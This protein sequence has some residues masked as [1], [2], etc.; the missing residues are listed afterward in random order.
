MRKMIAGLA[1]GILLAL[2]GVA[3]ADGT[4][5]EGYD[6]N[7]SVNGDPFYGKW[8]IVDDRPFVGVEALSDL[9]EIPRV[10]NY[11]AWNIDRQGMDGGDPLMLMTQTKDGEIKTIRYAGVTMVDLYGVAAALDLPVHHNFRN[12]TIQ[13]GSNY[14]GE[15]MKGKWYRYLSRRRG[16]NLET[17]IDRLRPGVMD[18]TDYQEFHDS[19]KERQRF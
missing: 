9:L 11:K 12:K 3:S 17:D 16:W 14:T 1:T 4:T 6:V 5:C 15:E 10:H 19:P 7:L 2:G 18:Y 13:V 8:A